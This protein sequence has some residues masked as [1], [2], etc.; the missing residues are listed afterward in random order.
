MMWTSKLEY[1][2]DKQ[3]TLHIL[4]V[5]WVP[6]WS[7]LKI[8]LTLISFWDFFHLSSAEQQNQ[9]NQYWKPL[10]ESFE[11]FFWVFIYYT[12]LIDLKGIHCH[13]HRCNH[14]IK[15]NAYYLA[16]LV[17]FRSPCVNYLLHIWFYP[18]FEC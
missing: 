8:N 16:L 14:T 5:L 11:S 7:I 2:K 9:F 13:F 4:Q 6:H 3:G 15:E 18:H 12:I 17:T 1:T 10:P